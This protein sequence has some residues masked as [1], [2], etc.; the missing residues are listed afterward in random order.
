MRQYARTVTA[1]L[2][3]EIGTWDVKSNRIINIFEK[4]LELLRDNLQVSV[5]GHLA[6]Q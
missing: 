6:Y 4:D 2:K 3:L 5:S 1:Y